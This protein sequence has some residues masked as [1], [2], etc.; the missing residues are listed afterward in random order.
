MPVNVP[1]LVTACCAEAPD[2]SVPEQRV[3]IGQTICQYREPK[4]IAVPV[5][6]GMDA[7]ALCVAALARVLEVPAANGVDV[8]ISRGGE[9]TRT[10]A[11]SNAILARDRG[12]KS[13][14]A[15][16]IVITPS[17]NPPNRRDCL[18]TY[19]TDLADVPG[20]AVDPTFRFTAVNWDG[21]IIDH[22][23]AKLG[24]SLGGAGRLQAVPR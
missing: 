15:D 3:A 6:L 21:R 1:R 4:R 12:R 17:H 18:D 7:H 8:T 22:I 20:M 2:P 11:V 24:R 13:G 14:P 5:F 9:Y 10:P 19:V 16:G 23:A